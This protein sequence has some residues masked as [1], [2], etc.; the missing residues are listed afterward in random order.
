MLITRATL[1]AAS[2]AILRAADEIKRKPKCIP[3]ESAQ[4]FGPQDCFLLSMWRD[5]DQT[6]AQLEHVDPETSAVTHL[7]SGTDCNPYRAAIC[8]LTTLADR[9]AR[10]EGSSGP[11]KLS[12]HPWTRE[13]PTPRNNH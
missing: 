4:Y 2:N 6:R 12:A 9:Q 7:A 1:A 11:A 8:I 13:T 10:E 3:A 5:N